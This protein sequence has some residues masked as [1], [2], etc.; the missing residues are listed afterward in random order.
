VKLR[1]TAKPRSG[2]NEAQARS[3]RW[4]SAVVLG[5][6]V[7]GAVGLAAR[8]V[9][10]QLLDH[11][12]LAKQGDDR[13][14]RVVKIAAHRGAITDRNGEPL[15]MSTPVDSIW[16]NPE[17]LNDNIDTYVDRKDDI[18]KPLK[19]IIEAD[20]EFQAKLRALKDAA[21][22]APEE[23]H[24]YEFVLTNLLETLDASTEEH[25]KLLAEQDEAA[26]H[27]KLNSNSSA[28]TPGKPE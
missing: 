21:G 8:A 5:L 23:A 9:E 25:R 11:G 28:K 10:L 1:F 14:M 22:V 13:S 26:K 12:F 20:T 18:R 15:A 19:I 2:E 24:A 27:K 4:R 7:A 16:V 17:E 6:V 3:F